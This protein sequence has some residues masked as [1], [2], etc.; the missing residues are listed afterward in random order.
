M[1]SFPTT[2][3]VEIATLPTLI[4]NNYSDGDRNDAISIINHSH[5]F[6][7]PTT[8]RG[9][10]RIAIRKPSVSKWIGK[11]SNDTPKLVPVR[12]SSNPFIT[13]FPEE[14]GNDMA[15]DIDMNM[16]DHT[17]NIVHHQSHSTTDLQR[18]KTTANAKNGV[19]AAG[20]AL[21]IRHQTSESHCQKLLNDTNHLKPIMLDG[22]LRSKSRPS[23]RSS[24]MQKV[25]SFMGKFRKSSSSLNTNRNTDCKSDQE[26]V[27]EEVVDRQTLFQE[28]FADVAAFRISIEGKSNEEYIKDLFAVDMDLDDIHDQP[29]TCGNL[30]SL[31]VKYNSLFI[32]ISVFTHFIR[33]FYFKFLFFRTRLL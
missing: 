26:V 16:P 23:S 30:C 2:E 1:A 28:N 21:K 9:T 5:P 31:S 32:C 6:S 12:S 25:S 4:E 29:K 14:V 33:F 17:P 13:G 7:A 24:L 3:S 15:M 19:S 22:L 20:V 27:N 10:K 18:Y 8:P 11:V